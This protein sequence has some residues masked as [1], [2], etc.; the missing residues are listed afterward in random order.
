MD[1]RRPRLHRLKLSRLPQRLRPVLMN[2]GLARDG[3]AGPAGRVRR[4]DENHSTKISV[5][6]AS[7]KP[8]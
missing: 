7:P 8:T 3:G 2:F 6:S 4:R 5:A 1:Y